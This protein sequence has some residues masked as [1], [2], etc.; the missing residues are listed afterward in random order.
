MCMTDDNELQIFWDQKV[1]T[2]FRKLDCGCV[3][4]WDIAP[5]REP[6]RSIQLCDEHS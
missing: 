5:D 3:M 4:H 2:D 6:I 1:S